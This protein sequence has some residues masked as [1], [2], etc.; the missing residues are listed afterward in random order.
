VPRDDRLYSGFVRHDYVLAFAVADEAA[1]AALR[2]LCAGPWQ[3][4]EVTPG[5]WEISNDLDPDAMESAI[6]A[7]LGEGDRAVYYYLSDSKR[8]FRVVLAG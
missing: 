4:D 6:L 1:R 2:D 8:L 7:L 3:G 5:T